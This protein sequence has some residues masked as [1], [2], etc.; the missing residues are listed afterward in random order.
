MQNENAKSVRDGVTKVFLIV[1]LSL[2]WMRF[3]IK[4]IE[5]WFLLK[6]DVRETLGV[7]LVLYCAWCLHMARDSSKR[8]QISLSLASVVLAFV[9]RIVW[10]LV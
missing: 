3:L 7:F 5:R 2:I 1:V 6:P 4:L 8:A 9:Y 10:M